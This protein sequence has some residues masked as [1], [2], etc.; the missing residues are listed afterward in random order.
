MQITWH[1]GM[2]R[3]SDGHF[4]NFATGI[5]NIYIFLFLLSAEILQ[6]LLAIWNAISYHPNHTIADNS[7]LTDGIV[8]VNRQKHSGNTASQTDM[9]T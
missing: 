1:H 5:F 2:A 9:T 8:V 4:C 7:T 3:D 6:M